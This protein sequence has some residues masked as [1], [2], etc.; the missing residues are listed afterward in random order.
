MLV[1]I[2]PYRVRLE[3]WGVDFGDL[4]FWMSDFLVSKRFRDSYLASAL[5]NIGDFENVEVLS[6]RKYRKLRGELPSYYRAMPKIGSARI[7]PEASEIEWGDGKQPEC[8]VCLSGAG[9]IKR[10][11]R[12]VI[13]ESSWNGDDVFYPFGLTGSLVVTKRFADWALKYDFKNLVLED[14]EASSHD[15]YPMESKPSG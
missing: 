1:A 11:K 3:T 12:I 13:D 15:F 8:N 4:V 5:T 14:A 2:P 9:V 10:W 7:D 6:C